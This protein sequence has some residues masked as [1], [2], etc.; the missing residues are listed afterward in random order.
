LQHV[1]LAYERAK[2]ALPF[3]LQFHDCGPGS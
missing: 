3:N 1:I 2:S